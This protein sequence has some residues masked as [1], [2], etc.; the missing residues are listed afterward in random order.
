MIYAFGSVSAAQTGKTTLALNLVIW[1]NQ[2]GRNVLLIETKS[3]GPAALFTE[4]RK[5]T[6]GSTPVYCIAQVAGD[7]LKIKLPELHR[8]YDDL[9]IDLETYDEISQKITFFH[10]D[11]ILIPFLP[12]SNDT[13]SDIL[14]K[15]IM[16][17]QKNRK[18]NFRVYSCINM[19]NLPGTSENNVRRGL[20]SIEGLTKPVLSVSYH[21]AFK[22]AAIKGRSNF[23]MELLKEKI[24]DEVNEFFTA[25]A[26]EEKPSA[27][28][29]KGK[30]NE[31]ITV[32]ANEEKP[33]EKS[34]KVEETFKSMNVKLTSEEI[35]QIRSIRERMPNPSRSAEKRLTVSLH[36][37]I[38]IAVQEKIKREFKE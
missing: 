5:R 9:I 7:N 14:S 35:A 13:D 17:L 1:L 15:T 8:Q 37:W 18:D 3:Q 25:I 11:I 26:N 29:S 19:A 36:D 24:N 32:I 2:K 12:W 31:L 10:S 38:V 34:S 20:L 27:K 6:L 30:V 21:S 22:A 16:E 33:S 28:S 23:E 4:V